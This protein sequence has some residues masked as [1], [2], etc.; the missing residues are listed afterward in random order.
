[1]V[2]GPVADGR[3]VE[4]AGSEVSAA[5][6]SEVEAPPANGRL[7]LALRTHAARLATR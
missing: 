6:A 5:A 2:D 7:R 4:V 1:V 3:A